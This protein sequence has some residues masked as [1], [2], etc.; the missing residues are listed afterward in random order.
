MLSGSFQWDDPNS[1]KSVA[2]R[3]AIDKIN[4]SYAG[5]SWGIRKRYQCLSSSLWDS[6]FIGNLWN[7]QFSYLG[8]G[9]F[10]VPQW[11][12]S[13]AEFRTT[14]LYH[15]FPSEP[16]RHPACSHHW[17]LLFG[18][19]MQVLR[20][21]R[22]EKVHVGIFSSK[23]KSIAMLCQSQISVMKNMN[24]LKSQGSLLSPEE[25][26]WWMSLYFPCLVI[27][28]RPFISHWWWYSLLC[29]F[30]SKIWSFKCHKTGSFVMSTPKLLSFRFTGTFSMHSFICSFIQQTIIFVYLF[31][32]LFMFGCLGSSLLHADFLFSCSEWGDNCCS[33]QASH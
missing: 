2:G 3:G 16:R 4:A 23:P 17:S 7:H 12:W 32:Y 27:L 20:Q 15:L 8:M 13:I 33:A 29:N 9:F 1:W 22:E 5:I 30:I 18:S 24:L 21:E 14:D 19:P 6:T 31:I 11:F 26:N 25:T 28:S 10:K